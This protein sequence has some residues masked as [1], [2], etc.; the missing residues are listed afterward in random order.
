MMHPIARRFLMHA[1]LLMRCPRGA[2]SVPALSHRGPRKVVTSTT[3]SVRSPFEHLNGAK[4]YR[5]MFHA[6]R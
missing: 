4:S 3:E 6:R 5:R 1:V 2:E